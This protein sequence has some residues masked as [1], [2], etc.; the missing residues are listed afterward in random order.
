[1]K[2]N[3]LEIEEDSLINCN[4]GLFN[5]SF[6]IDDDRCCNIEEIG[7]D[8]KIISFKEINVN[9]EELMLSTPKRK[10]NVSFAGDLFTPEKKCKSIF[11]CNTPEAD[12]KEL[13]K[14][15]RTYIL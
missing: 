4:S 7:Y 6:K 14:N 12:L 2:E 9:K 13:L 1:L 8:E 15:S 11:V 10:L 5:S 3:I